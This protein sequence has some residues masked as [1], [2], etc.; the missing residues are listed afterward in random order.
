MAIP[1]C[2]L[3]QLSAKTKKSVVDAESG[4]LGILPETTYVSCR[5]ACGFAVTWRYENTVTRRPPM[6][7]VHC[8]KSRYLSSARTWPGGPGRRRSRKRREP[9]ALSKSHPAKRAAA[10][11]RSAWVV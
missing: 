2:R 6:T 1:R 10:D 9:S 5:G 7:R 8:L 4:E 3:N 11:A